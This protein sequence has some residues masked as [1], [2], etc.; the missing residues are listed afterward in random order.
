MWSLRHI[1]TH[2]KSPHTLDKCPG[3]FP[4]G[5]EETVHVIVKAIISIIKMDIQEA[6]WTLQLCA[7]HEAG[8]EVAICMT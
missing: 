6:A 2:D 8:C 4:I 3:I 5:T 7:G 1:C